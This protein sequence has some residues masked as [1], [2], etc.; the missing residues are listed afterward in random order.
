MSVKL[1]IESK[2]K[3]FDRF[4][5][6]SRLGSSYKETQKRISV[7]KILLLTEYGFR[8]HA[9]SGIEPN[10]ND[11]TMGFRLGRGT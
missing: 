3:S 9:K 7:D 11:R 1:V 2:S 6:I 5:N 4:G 8:L 10:Q